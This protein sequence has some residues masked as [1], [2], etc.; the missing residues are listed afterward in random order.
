[1]QKTVL[2]NLLKNPSEFSVTRTWQSDRRSPAMW[3]LSYLTRHKFAIFVIFIGAFGNGIGAGILPVFVGWGFDVIINPPIDLDFL[4]WI[5]IGLIISQ[6][7][8]SILM[9][10]RNFYSELLGQRIERDTRDELYLDLLGKSM[11]FHD[12]QITG[13]LM[14]RA[15]NDVRE[16]N[17]LVTPGVNMV[18]G[19]I[20]FIIA[21]FII[22]PTIHLHL[23]FVPFLYTIAYIISLIYYLY[24]LRPAT[25]KVRVTFGKLNSNL[26]EA[27]DGVETIKGAAQEDKEIERFSHSLLKWRNAFVW[28]GDIEAK[29]YALLLLGLLQAGALLHS[30]VLFRQGQ[31][32]VGDVVAFNG[33][34]QIFGFPTFAAQFAY[35]FISS[36]LSSASRILELMHIKTDL[37]QNVVGHSDTIDGGIEFQNVTF[38]YNNSTP[39]LENITFSVQPGQTVAIVGQTGT[40]KST[41]AKLINRTYDVNKGFIRVGGHDVQDWNLESLRQQ[42]SII[43]Q[44]VYLF[45]RSIAANI[46]FGVP[47]ASREQ[48]ITAAKTAQAHDFIL[49]FKDGYDT[50]VGER[51]FTLSGG[52]RQRLALARAFLTDPQILILDDATSAID[53]ATEDK[54]QRAIEQVA[55][56]RTTILITHRLSQIRWADLI[57]VLQKGR[58]AMMG[59]HETLLRE[60]E[61]Y[62]N[63]FARYM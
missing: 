38:S 35:A 57:V 62:R 9:F 31:I 21:P 50:V 17:L 32:T 25:E 60:S 6:V 16:I 3:I 55:Q 58:V 40:G 1:M 44:D 8:R 10:G 59:N 30:L 53:S 42:I 18:I 48:I 37:D 47:N 23:L 4:A 63:I 43:E 5:A 49:D 20:N 2:S 33:M 61:A 28:Q 56:G 12:S 51:G 27:I 13:D 24:D 41:I 14:A 7:I 22:I 54:I 46:A 19:S 34:M 39:A 11:T 45:S 15:T 52:Q 36:G 29:F 26:A